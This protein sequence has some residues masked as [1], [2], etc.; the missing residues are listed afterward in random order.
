MRSLG[1]RLSRHTY[2][3]G[4]V[5][6]QSEVEARSQHFPFPKHPFAGEGIF[7]DKSQHSKQHSSRHSPTSRTTLPF[8]ELCTNTTLGSAPMSKPEVDPWLPDTNHIQ[9]SRV[10]M[11]GF[12]FPSLMYIVT[13]I[14]LTRKYP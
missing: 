13:G 14:H 7:Q 4:F 1:G 11:C 9:G 3:I 8:L 5:Q 12:S 2:L 10:P 6:G